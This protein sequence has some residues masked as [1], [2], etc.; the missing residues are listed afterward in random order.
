M[1]KI[2]TIMCRVR[3]WIMGHRC[4]DQKVVSKSFRRSTGE[5][6]DWEQYYC[7]CCQNHDNPVAGQYLER[8]NLFQRTICLW[9]IRLQ[10]KW[11]FRKFGQLT[12][13]K[14]PEYR[15]FLDEQLKR[16]AQKPM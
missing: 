4:V 12:D 13:P 7:K 16:F 10:N 15:A 2:K 11:H 1:I 5:V 8:R 3:C 9:L 6:I 14:T